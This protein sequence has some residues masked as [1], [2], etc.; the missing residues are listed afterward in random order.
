MSVLS[1]ILWGGK[2]LMSVRETPPL[3]RREKRKGGGGKREKGI[4]I[5]VDI[6][7]LPYYIELRINRGEV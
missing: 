6:E 4:C 7:N 1:P 3:P 5:Y 2:S